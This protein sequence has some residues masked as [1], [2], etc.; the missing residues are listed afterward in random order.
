MYKIQMQLEALNDQ[1]LNSIIK[2]IESI[3]KDLLKENN[4]KF[5]TKMK[6]EILE[7]M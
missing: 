7:F 2:E 3:D 4:L 1:K 6:Q 5:P